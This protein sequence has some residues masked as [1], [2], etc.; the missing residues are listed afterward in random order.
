MAMT[1]TASKRN[2]IATTI[3]IMALG[4]KPSVRVAPAWG[5]G[6]ASGISKGADVGVERGRMVGREVV[7]GAIIKVCVC[8]CVC[9]DFYLLALLGLVQKS[10]HSI[11]VGT[12]RTPKYRTLRVASIRC[13]KE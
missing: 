11:L 13:C 12:L 4:L 10:C 9:V 7:V 2:T 5:A 1:G 6:G 3:P 8:V